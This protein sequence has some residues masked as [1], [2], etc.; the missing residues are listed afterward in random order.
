MFFCLSLNEDSMAFISLNP[1]DIGLLMELDLFGLE[2]I[3]LVSFNVHNLVCLL[4]FRAVTNPFP[5]CVMQSQVHNFA[6][7]PS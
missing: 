1:L 5:E 7:S 4:L 3:L 6:S 2:N